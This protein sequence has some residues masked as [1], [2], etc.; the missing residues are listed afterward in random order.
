MC[1]TSIKTKQNNKLRTRKS[2]WELKKLETNDKV[3]VPSLLE[4]FFLMRGKQVLIFENS[5]IS[6]V[7][8]V[9]DQ[10]DFC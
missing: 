1:H 10:S 3:P 5:I 4:D 9:L 7:V 8:V 6:I 2:T